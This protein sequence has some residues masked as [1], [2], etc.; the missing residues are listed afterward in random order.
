M[1]SVS[2]NLILYMDLLVRQ[3]PTTLIP[4]KRKEM[5]IFKK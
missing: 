5:P 3:L 1:R 4:R 2:S